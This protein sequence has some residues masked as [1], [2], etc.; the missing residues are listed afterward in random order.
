VH[1][2]VREVDE[3]GLDSE[4]SPFLKL[5]LLQAIQAV[6]DDRKMKRPRWR[7]RGRRP[8]NKGFGG[9][10]PRPILGFRTKNKVIIEG[11]RKERLEL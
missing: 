2:A 4:N 11:S 7:R 3:H 9:G 8:T 1:A 10:K 5:A 6:K